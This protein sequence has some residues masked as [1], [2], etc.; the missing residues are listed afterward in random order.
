MKAGGLLNGGAE[1]GSG[2]APVGFLDDEVM[3]EEETPNV[4]PEEQ[5][6]Y[7]AFVNNAMEVLYTEDGKVEEDVLSRLST[8]NKPIDV[9]AQTTVWLVMLIEQDA[10][11]R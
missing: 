2:T 11:Q 5:Q 9:L 8:G 6:E 4:S 1:G 3:P 7:D 10:H